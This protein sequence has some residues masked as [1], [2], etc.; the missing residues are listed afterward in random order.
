M[1][2]G[3]RHDHPQARF[4]LEGL[5]LVRASPALKTGGAQ[6]RVNLAGSGVARPKLLY[7]R[8]NA[9]LR[10][11]SIVIGVRS[12]RPLG[13]AFPCL[14]AACST[15]KPG[16]SRIR[17]GFTD[18]S[19]VAE[20]SPVLRQMR[21]TQDHPPPL[22]WPCTSW[23]GPRLRQIEEPEAKLGVHSAGSAHQV[24]TSL[25]RDGEARA[26]EQCHL[27]LIAIGEIRGGHR[28]QACKG[29]LP[30]TAYDR[31]IRGYHVGRSALVVCARKPLARN[32]YGGEASKAVRLPK[33]WKRGSSPRRSHA[34]HCCSLATKPVRCDNKDHTFR[35]EEGSYRTKCAS[36]AKLWDNNTA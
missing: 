34:G 14:R 2:R 8:A 32:A 17:R 30:V 12:R 9:G 22:I 29:L 35:K 10:D 26:A 1:V 28:L 15:P 20:T 21:P 36:P 11:R 18:G 3:E 24:R 25:R 31:T 19:A 23:A 4:I 7:L 27:F 6:R 5:Y 33:R 13:N 16:T